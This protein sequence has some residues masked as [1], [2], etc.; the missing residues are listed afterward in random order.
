MHSGRKHFACLD[1]NIA[2]KNKEEYLLHRK[3]NHLKSPKSEVSCD[4]CD[5][6]TNSKKKYLQHKLKHK[7]TDS[8]KNEK[9]R[10]GK[11]KKK[12]KKIHIKEKENS[13]KQC[14][15]EE[16]D[17]IEQIKEGS[18]SEYVENLKEEK[19][20]KFDL[21]C[22]DFP[23]ADPDMT[24]PDDKY[25]SEGATYVCPI[26]SCT[27]MTKILSDTLQTEHYRSCHPEV[28]TVNMQFLTLI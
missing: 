12:S 16:R 23:T 27:F 14:V 2:L 1:C 25:E 6:K 10:H 7:K 24:P 11:V 4:L 9:S 3:E 13:D 17:T 15:S 20:I 26:S 21:D 19:P 18:N 5:F 28:D 8:L 22:Q